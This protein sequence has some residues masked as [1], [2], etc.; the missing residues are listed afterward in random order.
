ML[1]L[2]IF[3]SMFEVSIF[4]L[5]VLRARSPCMR[6]AGWAGGRGAGRA[7]LQ[8][9]SSVPTRPARAASATRAGGA[10][11]GAPR[12]TAEMAYPGVSA[13]PVC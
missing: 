1:R 6:P 3:V 13:A 10:G 12:R 9:R 5:K 4:L 7:R 2:L 11:R 8:V